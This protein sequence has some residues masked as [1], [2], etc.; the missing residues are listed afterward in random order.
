VCTST[1]AACC[2][3]CKSVSDTAGCNWLKISATPGSRNSLQTYS[4]QYEA[5]PQGTR[6]PRHSPPGPAR[7]GSPVGAAVP[8]NPA[9]ATQCDRVGAERRRLSTVILRGEQPSD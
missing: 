8:W 1:E 6:H 5:G 4:R 9:P 3:V 2:R 7:G